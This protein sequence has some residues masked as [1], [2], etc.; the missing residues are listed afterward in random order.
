MFQQLKRKKIHRII[1]PFFSCSP[2]IKRS[3]AGWLSK[4]VLAHHKSVTIYVCYNFC[5]PHILYPKQLFGNY[6]SEKSRNDSKIVHFNI[7][8][9]YFFSP[10]TPSIWN[11]FFPSIKQSRAQWPIWLCLIH[12]TD[13]Y[14][15]SYSPF[16][17]SFIQSI[18][19]FFTVSIYFPLFNV[20]FI[21]GGLQQS[22]LA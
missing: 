16:W 19:P 20:Q 9:Y 15:E 5:L 12:L 13:N 3:Y 7:T 14:I 17:A 2:F 1:P 21:I 18:A 6:G 8:L 10:S 22:L 11:H 4:A